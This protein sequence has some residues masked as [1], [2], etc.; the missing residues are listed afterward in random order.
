MQYSGKKWTGKSDWLLF[1][2]TRRKTIQVRFKLQKNTTL[3]KKPLATPLRFHGQGG[4]TGKSPSARRFCGGSGA[5][6]SSF[7]HFMK[8]QVTQCYHRPA[9]IICIL[10]SQPH[11]LSWSPPCSVEPPSSHPPPLPTAVRC[12]KRDR[13]ACKALKANITNTMGRNIYSWCLEGS[14]YQFPLSTSLY[15]VSLK[16]FYATKCTVTPSY[17]GLVPW[18][19]S[20]KTGWKITFHTLFFSA[21]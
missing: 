8:L 14:S 4:N 5:E 3:L 15:I 18:Y 11:A 12:H 6:Y 9:R 2:S 13:E 21:W 20:I 16:L 17:Y 7:L 19:F 1:P 10:L